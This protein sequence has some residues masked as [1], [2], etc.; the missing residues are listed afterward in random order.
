MTSP[1]N[2]P[3]VLLLLLLLLG[4]ALP[5]PSA[6]QAQAESR[7]FPETGH[8]LK[9]KFLAY[10]NAHGGLAQLGYPISDE[11]PDVSDTNGKTYT[12]QYLERAVLELHP[13]NAGTPFEVQGS[14]IGVFAYHG[15]YPSLGG[16][17]GQ[18]ASSSNALQ[19]KETGKS[20]GGAFRTYWE[21]H[22]GL[23]QQGYPISNEFQ[24]KNDLNGQTYTVQ[25]F[26]RAV[27]ELHPENRVPFNVLLSQL[28]TF[29]SRSRQDLSYTD[30]TKTTVTLTK[31]PE[32]VVCLVALCEDIL[33]ELGMEPAAINDTFAQNP[34]FWGDK[35]K[36]FAQI[37]GGFA[38]PNLEDIAKIK[39][40][41]VIGFIPHIGLREALKPIAPLFIMNPASY[42]DS[43]AYL[44]T[45]GR[46]TNR[47]AK[48]EDSTRGFLQKMAAYKAKAPNNKV[49]LILFGTNTNFSIFTSGS[50]F[51]S[52]LSEVTNYPW[53]PPGAGDVGAPDQEPGSLQ[54]SLEKILQ[55]DPDVLLVESFNFAPGSPSLSQQL[56]ANPLW[57]ELKAV[58]TNQ[59]YEV[60]TAI[61]IFGRGT[62]SMSIALDDAM[63]KIYP[64]TFPNPLP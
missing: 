51:G 63:K 10:W 37:G 61:Y 11:T 64:E 28:G 60:R 45:I 3:F 44:H 7:L 8:T 42:Q 52:V 62:H 30:W 18:M 43:L 6:G 54:Y 4:L 26:E 55:K 16:A 2:R 40:D 58:K 20:L 17:P 9:G 48:A 15:K 50:L 46:L 33:F 59:V 31:H 5:H 23:A 1:R 19:F 29:Q 13:E 47:T 12:T 24:E 21:T 34:E 27:M 36:T 39:P 41:L 32:R 49:P 53:A 25:Y 22:G 38:A 56:K 57:S 35:G 14:L